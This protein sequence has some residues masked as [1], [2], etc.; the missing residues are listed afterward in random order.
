M[1]WEILRTGEQIQRSSA[2]SYVFAWMIINSRKRNL[3]QL[4]NCQ[5]KILTNCLEMHVFGTNWQIW[6]SLVSEHTRSINHKT[7]LQPFSFK[8]NAECHVQESWGTYVSMRFGRGVKEPPSWAQWKLSRKIRVL[9]TVRRAQEMDQSDASPS[10]KKLTWKCNQDPTTYSQGRRQ[11]DILSSSTG[12]LGRNGE[13]ASSVS[14]TKL[15]RSD[16]IQIGRRR[17][18]FHNMQCLR[19]SIPWESL[20]E[21][22]A[23]KV[24][25]RRRGTSNWYWNEDQCIDW[26]DCLSRQIMKVAIHLGPNYVENFGNTVTQT[27][28]NSRICSLSRRDW[29]WTI[30]PIFWMYHRLI[31]QLP[32]GRDLHLRTTKW[33]RGRKHTSTQIPS[34]AWGRCRSIQKRIKD[35]EANSRNFDS[36]ILTHRC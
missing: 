17:L 25:S 7:D 4:E 2:K 26:G 21:P 32:H 1:R 3:N 11:D 27:S 23:R 16:D 8:H 24:E 5:K 19:R 28:Q 12:K 31:G 9:R 22:A 29:R 6:H 30:K 33:S 34:H 20:Q 15:E 10:N 14:T 36:P 35:G 13:S 18:E